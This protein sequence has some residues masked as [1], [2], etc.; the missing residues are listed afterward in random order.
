LSI[1]TNP[2]LV[3]RIKLDLEKI[4]LAIFFAIFLFIGPG[5]LFNHQLKHDFPYAYLASDAFQHQV[6]AEAIKD[7]GNFRYEAFYISKGFNDVIG[8]YPPILYHI[9]A[10]F[11]Y[12]SGLEV[13]DS[14]YFIVFLFSGFAM[15][16][17]YLIVRDFNKNIALMSL[18]LSLLIFSRA[19]MTGFV[20]GHWPSL[21]GQFFLLA[22]FWSFIKFD[23]EK[24]Y[25]IIGI[26]IAASI[27]AHTASLI[28][29]SIFILLFLIMRLLFRNFNW[30]LIK[31][32]I[33]SG[34]IALVLTAYYLIIFKN[35]W[36]ITQPYQFFKM[37]VWEGNPGFYILD[38]KLVLLFIAIGMAFSL[39]TFKNKPNVA[40]LASFSMLFLGFGNYIGF[41]VRAFQIRFFWP[42]YLS[43]FF[44]FA[45]YQL[46]KFL[47]KEWR[48][49]Y[50]IIISFL[51]IFVFIGLLKIPF[52]LQYEKLSSSGLMDS[53]HWEAFNWI[54]KNTEENAKIYFLYG[55]IYSQD[56]LLRNSKRI[57]YQVDPEY[58][59][60][61]LNERKI[62]KSYIS[63]LPG[64]NG[65]G[66]VYRKS[67]FSFADHGN[68]MPKEFSFGSQNICNFDYFVVDK[69][70]RQNALAQYNLL[71]A[72]DLINKS[73]Q[74]V[75]QNDAVAVIKNNKV[76]EDCIE[77]RSF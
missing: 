57:H 40:T 55:D 47:I 43:F 17:F 66:L 2:N 42:L 56:A 26:L 54:E 30:V 52:I 61:S 24:F 75:F 14:I 48:I 68:E 29:A 62:K 45:I 1:K 76:G 6:R 16:I 51:F 21:L 9:A 12:S 70:S 71:I 53:Y 59:I 38:F 33:Y 37:P 41:D 13:Y 32:I 20:W 11:S 69:A 36:M 4:F 8:R 35:T 15:L 39:L 25:V 44:G 64:D 7:A 27:L 67:F 60:K 50:S 18:P 19:P 63:E 3:I 77:E 49:I 73:A 58:Y 10:I 65:G 72:N 74:V 31:K 46:L 5:I 34:I 23:T 28:F 22:L